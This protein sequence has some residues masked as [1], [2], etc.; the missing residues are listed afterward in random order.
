MIALGDR[1]SAERD[2]ADHE[3]PNVLT[4]GTPH[5]CLWAVVLG[6]GQIDVLDDDAGGGK[7][8]GAMPT[9]S[10]VVPALNEERNI[11]HVFEQILEEIHLVVLVD[12]C[13]VDDTVA[14]ER[15]FG[16]S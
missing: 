7:G 16:Q 9:V 6:D 2:V 12:G 11:P 10:M 13:S 4:A 15:Q 3:V 1:S 8:A 5:V 14:M